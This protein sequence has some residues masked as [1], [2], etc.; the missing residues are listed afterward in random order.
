MI[1]TRPWWYL[2]QTFVFLP[3]TVVIAIGLIL[4]WVHRRKSPKEI[5]CIAAGLSVIQSDIYLGGVLDTMPH[6]SIITFTN[7]FRLPLPMPLL[8]WTWHWPSSLLRAVGILLVLWG[9]FAAI[10]KADD[11]ARF[12]NE[13]RSR[14]TE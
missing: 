12:S 11:L 10:R 3:Q 13:T 7:Y 2:A 4:C 6:L 9:V 1:E 8:E 14:T 5:R